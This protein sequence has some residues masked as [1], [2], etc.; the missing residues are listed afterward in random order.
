MLSPSK[1]VKTSVSAFS[2][3]RRFSERYPAPPQASRQVW[4]ASVACHVAIAYRPAARVSSSRRS[5]SASSS[6][7]PSEPKMRS[8][9]ATT[10]S[11][12]KCSA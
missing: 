12:A 8:S 9:S 6:P 3:P 7:S 4:M 2:S 10:R 1:V 11:W 5:R